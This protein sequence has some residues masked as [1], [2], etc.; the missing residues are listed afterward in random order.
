M[1]I[2]QSWQNAAARVVLHRAERGEQSIRETCPSTQIW[3]LLSGEWNERG[4]GRRGRVQRYD[5]RRYAPRQPCRR[6]VDEDSVA[7]GIELFHLQGSPVLSPTQVRTTWQIAH[8]I[9]AGRI[10]DFRLEEQLGCFSETPALLDHENAW[11][12]EATDIVYA[13]FRE[14]LT[15]G[16]IAAR[17]GISP[18][19]LS[20]SFKAVNGLPLS[21]MLRRLRLED[22]LRRM[23]SVPDAWLDAG[24][25]DVSHF[26]RACQ[27]DLGL[28]PRQIRLL[29]S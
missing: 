1:A 21:K 25:Y 4:D 19:H 5:V 16:G 17:V 14:P 3:L 9:L 10:D 29:K 28:T 12:R 22:A 15:L 26:W 24:F 13:E 27:Q 11:L 23:D 6:V 7:V 2:L 8:Q 20:A 18:N